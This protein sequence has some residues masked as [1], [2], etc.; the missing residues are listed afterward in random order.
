MQNI[1]QHDVLPISAAMNDNR[2]VLSQHPEMVYSVISTIDIPD[3]VEIRAV[4]FQSDIRRI[5]EMENDFGSD[6]IEPSYGMMTEDD[7]DEICLVAEKDGRL[8]GQISCS[9]AVSGDTNTDADLW[10]S[11]IFVSYPERGQGISVAMGMAAIM[12]CEKW[13]RHVAALRGHDPEGCISV[14][15]DTEPGSAAEAVIDRC[16]EFALLLENEISE[17]KD[18]MAR[19]AMTC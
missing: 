6:R 9:I 14:D 11:G 10:V 3:D 1:G 13:R 7:D 5:G 12:I 2:F 15:A 8:V 19:M 17:M 16:R 4:D 18:D